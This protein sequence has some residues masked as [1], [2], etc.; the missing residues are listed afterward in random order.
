VDRVL[1]KEI[2][3][4]RIL[5]LFVCYL[6][7]LLVSIFFVGFRFDGVWA[8]FV[9]GLVLLYWPVLVPIAIADEYQRVK[10]DK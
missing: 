3:R 5:G 4:K 9:N 6:S 7:P 2:L 8:I 1:I 10:K